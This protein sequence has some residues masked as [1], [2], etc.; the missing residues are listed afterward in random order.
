MGMLEL[1]DRQS[2]SSEFRLESQG[3]ALKIMGEVA[4]MGATL[5]GEETHNQLKTVFQQRA[6]AYVNAAKGN[7]HENDDDDEN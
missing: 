1:L 6:L 3:R 7:G 4:Q 2:S 5:L